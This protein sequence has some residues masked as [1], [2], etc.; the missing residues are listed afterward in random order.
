VVIV[1]QRRGT[2]EGFVF[3]GL[4]DETG[5]GRGLRPQLPNGILAVRGKLGADGVTNLQ[6]HAFF[7]PS[8]CLTLGCSGCG[9]LL[10]LRRKVLRAGAALMTLVSFGGVWQPRAA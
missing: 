8:V 5:A 4:E 9:A 1:H 10:G 2:G 6:A 3:V 7:P